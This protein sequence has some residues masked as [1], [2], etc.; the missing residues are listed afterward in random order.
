LDFQKVVEEIS[1]QADALGSRYTGVESA[2]ARVNDAIEEW[3][4][5]CMTSEPNTS[6]RLGCLQPLN[7]IMTADTAIMS[8][9]HEVESP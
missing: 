3:A 8:A 6:E 7:R 2:T 5:T 4:S 1:D 9:I